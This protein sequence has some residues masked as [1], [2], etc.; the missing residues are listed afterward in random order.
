M[1]TPRKV[2]YRK[3]QKGPL[4]KGKD[5]RGTYIAFGKF[6]LKAMEPGILKNKHL[7]AIRMAILRTLKGKG[8]YWIR[9]F[10]HQSYTS[11]G[12][13]FSM[14]GGKGDVVGYMTKIKAGRIIVEI[15]GV[16]EEVAKEAL[17]I[18]SHKLPFKT[19]FVKE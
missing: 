4:P 10:P 16:P 12:V 5:T 6:G 13:E 3:Q 9:V 14:G 18:A 19:K 7:E 17:R 1:F 8:K 2:K 15:D 11:K